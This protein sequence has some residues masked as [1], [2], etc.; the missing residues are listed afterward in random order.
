MI[1]W[2]ELHYALI[3]GIA[4]PI[5]IAILGIFKIRKML[6]NQA[7]GNN[8]I[9]IITEKDANISD[10][11]K[12]TNQTSQS[13]IQIAGNNNQVNNVDLNAVKSMAT[14]ISMAM[15]PHTERAFNKIGL[16]THEFLSIL[17]TK[18]EKL[19]PEELEK[20]S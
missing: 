20:F 7:T 18:F 17:N 6:K 14:A 11:L 1:E 2:I 19:S 3:T 9:Q 16:N 5:I 13:G 4:V 15:Y 12:T 10:S 8:N